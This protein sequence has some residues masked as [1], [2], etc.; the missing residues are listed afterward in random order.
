MKA[1]I[2]SL[3]EL[4]ETLV[5]MYEEKIKLLTEEFTKKGDSNNENNQKK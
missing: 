1:K 3:T 4:T 2:V 5:D